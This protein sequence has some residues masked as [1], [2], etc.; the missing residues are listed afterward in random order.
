MASQHLIRGLQDV[1]IADRPEVGGKGASLGEL[2]RAGARVPAGYVVTAQAFE[3]AIA[4]IDPSGAIRAEIGQ[5]AAGDDAGIARVSAQARRRIVSAPLSSEV[6]AAIAAGYQ[7]LAAGDAGRPQVP[8]AVRSSATSEDSA[9]ASFAGVADTYLWVHG[10][11]AVTD[12]GRKCWASLY[13][14]Q[15]VASPLRNHIGEEALAMAVVVQ[16]MVLPRCAGGLFTCS[17]PTGHPAR[18][19][20]Q[21]RLAAGALR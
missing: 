6:R 4:V 16:R 5:L 20:H 18:V 21:A 9:T 11:P 1:A 12:S 19:P 7:L 14:A 17:P 13:N 8:V 2:V 3:R 10:A 15:A